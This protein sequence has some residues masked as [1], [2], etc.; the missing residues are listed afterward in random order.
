M[1]AIAAVISLRGEPLPV[2]K[3]LAA[4]QRVMQFE[5]NPSRFDVT[6]PDGGVLVQR[7]LA[8]RTR[9]TSPLIEQDDVVVA[10]DGCLQNRED[11]RR[12]LLPD[13]TSPSDSLLVL[14]AYLKWGQACPAH[15]YGFFSLLIWNRDSH[16]IF[17]ATD[18]MAQR[19]LFYCADR[20]QIAVASLPHALTKSG[21]V[22]LELDPRQI[23]RYLLPSFVRK[24]EAFFRGVCRVAGGTSVTIR[25]AGV[26]KHR[27]WHPEDIASTREFVP[28][29][30]HPEFQEALSHAIGGAIKLRSHGHLGLFMSGG[31][32]SSAIA[33]AAEKIR[34]RETTDWSLMATASWPT[35]RTTDDDQHFGELLR[36]AKH[37]PLFPVNGLN[38]PAETLSI[39]FDG[40][41]APPANMD[42]PVIAMML[43]TLKQ[44]GV[45]L[46][47][48]GE[49]GEVA[50]SSSARGLLPE[51]F[52]TLH[53]GQL[54]SEV[55]NRHRAG[56]ESWASLIGETL[57][58]FVPDSLLSA[59]GATKCQVPWQNLIDAHFVNSDFADTLRRDGFRQEVFSAVFYPNRWHPRSKR[60]VRRNDLDGIAAVH[61]DICQRGLGFGIEIS[62]PLVDRRLI[63]LAFQ[64]SPK[65]RSRGGQSRRLIRDSLR[66]IVPDQIL[67]RRTKSPLFPDY[68]AWLIQQQGRWQDLANG[69]SANDRSYDYVDLTR[70]K[71]TVNRLCHSP[72][73]VPIQTLHYLHRADV[74]IRFVQW[75]TAG[76][77]NG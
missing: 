60:K 31:L 39:Y 10:F 29:V 38:A 76:E 4:I 12:T 71:E 16:E 20:D 9:D 25:A 43:E 27:Y 53:W 52:G 73:S 14:A 3:S 66:G 32:D 5:Q 35:T 49:G 24:G 62:C 75:A 42:Y 77:H 69:L 2:A 1:D 15:L 58:P 55:Q 26:E 23:A 70:F 68:P 7:Q 18:H 45:S 51:L 30:D 33:C 72:D 13:E 65:C 47:L 64:L 28:E 41:G 46:V 61:S 44:R 34:H 57:F 54:L 17:L 48:D 74:L 6:K 37:L 40:T 21:V 67:N 22:P 36:D 19:P 59:C 63:E 11:L 50:A 8:S 56:S